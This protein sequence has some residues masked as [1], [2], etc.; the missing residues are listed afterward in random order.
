MTAPALVL[1]QRSTCE[2]R[3]QIYS[4]YLGRTMTHEICASAP[5]I[6]ADVECLRSNPDGFCRAYGLEPPPPSAA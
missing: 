3:H 1:V 6:P 2:R 4:R 5:M